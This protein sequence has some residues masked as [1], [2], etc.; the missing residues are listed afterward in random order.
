MQNK[1]L[2]YRPVEENLSPGLSVPSGTSSIL[3][4]FATQF[5]NSRVSFAVTLPDGSSQHFGPSAP[6]FKIIL[7]NSRAM[8]AILSLDEGR[9]G[10]AYLANDIDLEGDILDLFVLRESFSDVHPLTTIWRF[11][12][13]LMFGQV[14]TNKQ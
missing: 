9:F 5:A 2:T 3:G 13:P 1:D 12:Q 8:R 4:R 10:D 14:H 11:L 7:K 6:S